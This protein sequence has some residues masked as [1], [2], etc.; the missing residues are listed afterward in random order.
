MNLYGPVL[1]LLKPLIKKPQPTHTL[2]PESLIL[3]HVQCD[4]TVTFDVRHCI[5]FSPDVFGYHVDQI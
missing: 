4:A 3:E 1:N 5:S 2:L